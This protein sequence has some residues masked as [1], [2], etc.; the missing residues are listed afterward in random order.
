M[1]DLSKMQEVKSVRVGRQNFGDLV[2]TVILG[3]G[4]F[5]GQHG[6]DRFFY[7]SSM[8]FVLFRVPKGFRER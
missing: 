2:V 3:H 1:L 4:S 7:R 6:K 8:R 5:G